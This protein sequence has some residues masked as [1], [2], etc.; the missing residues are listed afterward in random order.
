[1]LPLRFN[2]YYYFIFSI[3][4]V[5]LLIQVANWLQ[6]YKN[7][8]E[9]GIFRYLF[10]LKRKKVEKFPLLIQLFDDVEFHKFY[11]TGCG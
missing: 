9:K 8:N 7:N 2:Y 10:W 1:M 11:L 3:R 5:L 6:K 4:I